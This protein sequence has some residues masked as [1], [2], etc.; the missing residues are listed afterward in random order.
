MKYL[1]S[2]ASLALCIMAASCQ[3]PPIDPDPPDKPTVKQGT[4]TWDANVGQDSVLYYTTYH[5]I[6]SRVYSDAIDTPDS[7][8]TAIFDSLS[9]T[10]WH[11]FAVTATNQHAQSNFSNEAVL[12]PDGEAEYDTL[13]WQEL[14]ELTVVRIIKAEEGLVLDPMQMPEKPVGHI[15][16]HPGAAKEIGFVCDGFADVQFYLVVSGGDDILLDTSE[17]VGGVY[18]YRDAL[19]A[20]DRIRFRLEIG[21]EIVTVTKFLVKP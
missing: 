5:G 4:V 7:V 1:P 8:L 17:T 14:D 21:D 10:E 18:F 12:V 16:F 2:F 3:P 13:R 9:L 19:Q 15:Q 11:Y 20:G 6:S